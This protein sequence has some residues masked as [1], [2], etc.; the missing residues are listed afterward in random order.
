[1]KTIAHFPDTGLFENFAADRMDVSAKSVQLTNQG[2]R[3]LVS[4]ER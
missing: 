3:T 1:M 4:N 2:S